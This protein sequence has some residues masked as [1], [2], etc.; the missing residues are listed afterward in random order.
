MFLR[1]VARVDPSLFVCSLVRSLPAQSAQPIVLK[2]LEI[3]G[4]F[5]VTAD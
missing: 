1:S 3:V 2:R 5:P 4:T